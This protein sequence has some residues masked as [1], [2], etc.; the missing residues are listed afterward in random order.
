V[1]TDR[2][3]YLFLII[4]IAMLSVTSISYAGTIVG[5]RHDLSALSK[6]GSHSGT[7][8]VIEDYQKICVYCHIPHNSNQN[9]GPLWN[10]PLPSA[11]SY[12]LYDSNTLDSSTT[13]IN[14]KSLLCLSCHDGTIA[15]DTLLNSPWTKTANYGDHM[16]AQQTSEN[17]GN[18]H[19]GG[20]ARKLG[21]FISQDLSNDHPVSFTYDSTLASTDGSLKDPSASS[22]LGGSIAS[23]MLTNG[24]LECTSCH[25]VHDPQYGNFLIK[26]SQNLCIT[27]HQK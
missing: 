15:V 18:C 24:Q 8:S 14:T 7:F 17:C 11:N 27:C 13:S 3:I 10:R 12:T 26:E 22:G 19:Y 25:D 6:K 20:I 2:N 16:R 1:K 5:S 21:S 4:L 9:G 23:D